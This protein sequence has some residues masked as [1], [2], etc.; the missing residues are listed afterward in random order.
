MKTCTFTVGGIALVVYAGGGF[1]QSLAAAQEPANAVSGW[2]APR[3]PFG[4]PDLQGMWANNSATPLERPEVFAEKPAFTEEELAAL[5]QRAADLFSS[6]GGDAAFSDQVFVAVA[7][8]AEEFTSSDGGTGNYN[9]FWLADREFDSRTSLVSDP[10]D[11]RVPLRSEVRQRMEAGRAQR[12]DDTVPVSWEQL[13][14]LTRCITN[15]LP[16]LL[17]GYNSNYQIVQTPNYVM[18]LQELMHEAR[19]IPL[20]GR[21]HLPSDIQ[22]LLGDSRGHWDGD[23]LVV[24]TTNFTNKT[25]LRGAGEHLHLTERIA[26]VSPDTIAYEFTVVDPTTFTQP[27]TAM[28]PLKKT[29]DLIFEYACHEGNHGLEGILAG[30]R[31]ED[32]AAGNAATER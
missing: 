25:S 12:A 13:G 15:G 6:D 11:G 28:I 9:Q 17:A 2:T 18:I 10:P 27:W 26:R 4:Q 7:T 21:P 1:A 30:A 3:T 29:E 8:G 23:T 24:E 5:K 31:A 22:Q 16:N 19:I 14:N 32:R 20:D